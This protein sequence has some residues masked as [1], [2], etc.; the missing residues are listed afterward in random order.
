MFISSLTGTFSSSSKIYFPVH[1]LAIA[2][3]STCIPFLVVREPDPKASSAQIAEKDLPRC[4]QSGC[5]G[6]LRP[7]V[8]WFGENLDTEVLLNTQ[9]ELEK[10]DLCLVVSCVKKPDRAREM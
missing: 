4:R 1:A 10:C 7:H 9:T 8:V 5:G 6:L 2:D 3:C